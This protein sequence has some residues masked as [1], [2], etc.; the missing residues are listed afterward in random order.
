M[1]ECRLQI[2]K[3]WRRETEQE[4]KGR[5]RAGHGHTDT[6]R[7]ESEKN[8]KQTHFWLTLNSHT[9]KLN[10]TRIRQKN[11]QD[12]TQE[13]RL[14]YLSTSVLKITFVLSN[15]QIPSKSI[16]TNCT[17]QICLIITVTYFIGIL[18]NR[19]TQLWSGRKILDDFLF[20]NR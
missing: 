5:S 7:Q 20:F 16:Q 15:R 9:S 6:D 4:S 11:K 12:K 13:T 14:F 10:K 18:C 1:L 19:A 8:Q 2:Y 17:F 3:A